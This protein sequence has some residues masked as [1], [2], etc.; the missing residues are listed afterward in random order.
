MTFFRLLLVLL[1]IPFTAHGQALIQPQLQQLPTNDNSNT[2]E[3]VVDIRSVM[4]GTT[5]AAGYLT[6]LTCSAP[7]TERLRAAIADTVPGGRTVLPPGCIL[8]D[9]TISFTSSVIEGVSQSRA[10]GTEIRF[11][12]SAEIAA[13]TLMGPGA[14]LTGVRITC[15]ANRLI[16][17]A[18]GIQLSDGKENPRGQRIDNVSLTDCYDQIDI[19]SGEFWSANNLDLYRARRW[20]FR[21]RNETHPDSGDGIISDSKIY[22]DVVAGGAAAIRLESGGGLKISTTKTLQFDRSFDLAVADE[23]HTSVLHISDS[24][25]FENPVTGE[26]IRLGRI[27]GGTTGSYKNIIV[28]AQLTG[29]LGVHPGVS[30]VTIATNT[31]NVP[32]G[33]IVQGGDNIN[34]TPATTLSGVEHGLVIQDPATNVTVGQFACSACAQT[35]EDNRT[36]GEGAIS[37]T[38]TR[39]INLPQSRSL[40]NLFRVDIKTFSGAKIELLTSGIIQGVGAV[41]SITAHLA[42]RANGSVT[43]T[44][45]STTDGGAAVDFRFDVSSIIGSVI[46]GIRP[47]LS[48]GGGNFTGIVT[49]KIDGRIVGFRLQA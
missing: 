23:A 49:I 33:V 19:R 47:N 14:R 40:K 13:F 30:N 10:V 9:D 17:R 5:F 21:I 4:K 8:I 42:T 48:V 7:Q 31:S 3:T 26:A 12:S 20:G 11:T 37:R 32:Y 18:R 35:I 34:V 45:I 27:E 29:A 1:A 25:S 41:N 24:N 39:K 43:M 46:V 38:E 6:D 44:Q 22:T 28:A 16:S 2:L 15:T 36:D